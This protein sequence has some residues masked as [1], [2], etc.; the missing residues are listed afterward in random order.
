MPA[1]VR[2]GPARRALLALAFGSFGLATGEFVMLGLLPNVAVS[3]HVSIPTAGYLISAYALGVVIG[4]PL[5]TAVSVRLPRKGLLVGLVLALAVGNFGSGLVRG[6]VPLLIFRFLSGLPHGAYFGVATVVASG[7]VDARRRSQAMGIVFAGLTVA[8]IVGV[9]VTT[10]VGQHAGWRVV[11]GAIGALEVLAAL[12]ITVVVPKPHRDEGAEAPALA[13]ELRAFRQSQVWLTLAVGVVGGGAMFASFSYIAP[14]MTHAAGY[15]ESS[16][17]LL[18]VLFGVGM[19]AGN[20]VG[21]RLADHNLMYA[22]YSALASESV[23]AALFFFTDRNKVTAAI[24]IALL[25]FTAMAI[26][27]A[28]QS[29]LITLAGEAPNLAAASMHSA[30]NVANSIGA[31]LGGLTIAAGYG[32][33]SPNLVAAGLAVLGLGIALYAG[34]RQRAPAAIGRELRIIGPPERSRSKAG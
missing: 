30:F 25:P 32:Y 31:W 5:L 20:F 6:Y 7:L 22:L 34:S 26:I 33:S 29:R 12:A 14:M 17:T 16:V 8:N 9:P 27:P 11:F 4:A 18:L 2:V 1:S 15:A 13:H 10:F 21:A 23:I 28:I 19:T 3:V 24:W